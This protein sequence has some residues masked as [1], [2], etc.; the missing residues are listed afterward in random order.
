MGEIKIKDNE[1]EKNI[2]P[3]GKVEDVVSKKENKEECSQQQIDKKIMLMENKLENIT[4]SNIDSGA[5]S[6][7]NP[8][9][10]DMEVGGLTVESS[11]SVSVCSLVDREQTSR[12]V[13]PNDAKQTIKTVEVK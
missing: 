6:S 8:T 11:K 13:L 5:Q 1:Q 3:K 12:T 2:R 7:I 10:E 9:T 4:I